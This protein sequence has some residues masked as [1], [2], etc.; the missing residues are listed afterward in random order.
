MSNKKKLWQIF[1]PVLA[2]FAL[3]AFV[4]LL[5]FSLTHFSQKSLKES[6]VSF[7]SQLVKGEAVKNAAFADKKVNYVPF[8]GSSELSRIDS[9]HPSVLAENY[10]RD[11]QPFMLGKAGSDSLVH[12]LNMQE[13][14]KTLK[15]KKAVYVVSPQW[16][17]KT[18]SDGGFDLFYSP[19]QVVDWMLN[20]GQNKPTKTDQFVASKVLDK[21]SV[22]NSPYYSRLLKQVAAGDK[23]TSA[24]LSTLRLKHRI[25]SRQ[26]AL[27]TRFEKTSNYKNRVLKAAK[28]LPEHY[29]ESALDRLGYDEGKKNTSN[30]DFHIKN[31]FYTTRVMAE[32]KALKGAQKD[33]DY[34]QSVEYA[35]FQSVLDN[36]AKNHTDVMFVITPVNQRWAKYTGLNNTMYQESV[37][38]IKYQLQ[39]Q[40]FNNIADLSRDGG[41]DYFMQDT[42]HVG[43][44]GWLALDQYLNP[45]L[46]GP[47]EKTNYQINNRFLSKDWQNLKPSTDNLADFK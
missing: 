21:G 1:G 20:L 4:F 19:L 6:S 10:H 31:S 16:F 46:S 14:Q 29:S 11:Y 3:L 38:K 45:F 25:L 9:L 5:P 40:G 34:T 47:T 15:T 41:E 27:F 8:F 26:D 23:L 7:S 22:K 33:Y 17:T 24:E 36:F 30:N 44:R 39:S 13:M 35:Y 18:G 28:P 2:A 32:K 43:W 42:I 12:F 37:A